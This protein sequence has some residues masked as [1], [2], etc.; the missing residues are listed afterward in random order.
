MS[1]TLETCNVCLAKIPDTPHQLQCRC[2]TH[3]HK[4]LVK[5]QLDRIKR[6]MNTVEAARQYPD[7]AWIHIHVLLS[8][9]SALEAAK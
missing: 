3:G 5:T 2:H 9:I 4:R 7:G 6:D 8:H 1:Y